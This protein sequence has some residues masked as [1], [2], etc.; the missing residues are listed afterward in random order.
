[1]KNAAIILLACIALIEGALA[2]SRVMP[3][4]RAAQ[5]FISEGK[6]FQCALPEGWTKIDAT[7][8]QSSEESRIYGVDIIGPLGDEEIAPS[9]SVKYFAK[10]NKLYRSAEEFIRMHSEPIPGLSIRG[11]EYGAVTDL[12]IAG[13]IATTFER[14]KHTFKRPRQVVNTPIP[15][16]EH[17]IVLRA[18]EGFYVLNLYSVFP[19]AKTNRLFFDSVVASFEPLIN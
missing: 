12:Q 16:Y 18:G 9:I 19:S 4:K 7:M 10:G 5:V 15:V 2:Q 3:D 6:Y 13:R 17:Y 1:M 11:D 14:K 8:G